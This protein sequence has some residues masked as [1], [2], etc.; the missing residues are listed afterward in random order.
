MHH[1]LQH[2]HHQHY[3]ALHYITLHLALQFGKEK[4]PE[5]R[6]KPRSIWKKISCVPA[7]RGSMVFEVQNY[8]KDISMNLLI[9]QAWLSHAARA[10]QAALC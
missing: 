1:H 2:A 6:E 5:L 7:F 10:H 4:T 3:I 8:I 9:M